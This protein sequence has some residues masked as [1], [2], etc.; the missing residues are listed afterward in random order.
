MN[1]LINSNASLQNELDAVRQNNAALKQENE[2]LLSIQA[3]LVEQL[4]AQNSSSDDNTMRV[5]SETCLQ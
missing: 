5:L 3:D 4:R 2:S 1:S